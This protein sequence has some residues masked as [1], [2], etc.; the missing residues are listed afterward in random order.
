LHG[1]GDDSSDE[2]STN[3]GSSDSSD[4][5]SSNGRTGW[6]YSLFLEL[7]MFN[8]GKNGKEGSPLNQEERIGTSYLAYDCYANIVC[9]A[10]HL[11]EVFLKTNLNVRVEQDDDESW[12]RFGPNNGE[13]KLKQSNADEF[14]YVVKQ[15]DSD[16]IIGYEGC[17]NID[18]HDPKMRSVVNNFVEVHFSRSGGETTSTGKPAS[19]GKYICLDPKCHPSTPSPSTSSSKYP[20]KRPTKGP[21]QNPTAAP[22][23]HPTKM[24]SP[25]STI[26]PS[27][28]PTN[29]VSTRNGYVCNPSH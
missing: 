5:L 22:T 3:G 13:T 8:G 15:D 26:T 4:M 9:V 18:L 24:P 2:G 19:N 1:I 21:V 14:K 12:I 27:S 17:W 25:S 16:F 7:P 10:A 23:A 29:L 6:E 11:D 20:S 28:I